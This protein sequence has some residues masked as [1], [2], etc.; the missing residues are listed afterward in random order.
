MMVGK[1]TPA[2]NRIDAPDR[3]HKPW[4]HRNV[5]PGNSKVDIQTHQ[6]TV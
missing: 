1:M 3:L 2:D 4:E 5:L 6:R